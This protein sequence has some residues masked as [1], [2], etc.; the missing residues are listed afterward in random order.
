MYYLK[1]KNT[2]EDNGFLSSTLAYFNTTDFEAG[3]SPVRSEFNVTICRY[4]EYRNPPWDQ[5]KYKRPMFYW[6][7][8]AFR[9]GFIVIFQNLVSF[10]TMIVQWAIPDMPKKLEDKIKIESLRTSDIIM[11]TEMM[12]AAAHKAET[13]S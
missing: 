3:I 7:I 1:I 9:L 2:P 11:K 12:R 6:Q 5:H 10:V 8:M 4:V 13:I